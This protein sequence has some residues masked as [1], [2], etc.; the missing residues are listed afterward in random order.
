MTRLRLRIDFEPGGSLGPG[1]VRL[2]EEVRTTGSISAAART[3]DMS[4]RRAWLLVDDLNRMFREPVVS[5]A[6]GGKRG[7]GSELTP[8]GERLIAEYRAI[9]RE[10]FA[11]ASARIAAL[12]AAISPD[13]DTGASAAF[14]DDPALKP[15]CVGRQTLARPVP[16]AKGRTAS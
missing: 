3:L 14:S 16:G 7:G 10:A 1:K 8:F 2:L 4:Y 13:A 15:G 6:V 12:Q 11:A 9:E 5:A